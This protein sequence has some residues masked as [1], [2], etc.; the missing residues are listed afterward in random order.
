MIKCWNLGYEKSKQKAHKIY[1]KIGRIQCPIFNNE[2][3][4]FTSSGFSHLIRKRGRVSRT[5][6][7]QKKRFV[8]LKYAERMVKE[9]THRVKIEFERREI[10][11]K[12]NRFGKKILIKKKANA[13]TL[14]ENIEGSEVKLVIGQVSGRGK[15]FVS[16]MSRDVVRST[17]PKNKIKK[18]P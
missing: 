15:E 2:L 8:L 6:T 13:W 4:S 7:E 14:V 5:K 18:S 10:M 3:V 1:R 11:E 12:V 17:P 9:P 16:I